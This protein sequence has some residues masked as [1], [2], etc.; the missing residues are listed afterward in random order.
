M[1]P[2][3]AVNTFKFLEL[4]KRESWYQMIVNIGRY[5]E[6]RYLNLYHKKK[7]WCIPI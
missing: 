1:N 2:C 7:V 3:T 5:R 6:L 4:K